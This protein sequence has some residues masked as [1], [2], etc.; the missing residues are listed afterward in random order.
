MTTRAATQSEFA[1]LAA[2]DLKNLMA[3][4]AQTT[5]E[6][7]AIAEK[8][9]ALE[10]KIAQTRADMNISMLLAIDSSTPPT[11]A[12]VLAAC[13]K[14]SQLL[15]NPVV[16]RFLTDCASRDLYSLLINLCYAGFSNNAGDHLSDAMPM[17]N[18]D[19]TAIAAQVQHDGRDFVIT[20]GMTK[21]FVLPRAIGDMIAG[22]H[23]NVFAAPFSTLAGRRDKKPTEPNVEYMERVNA[24]QNAMSEE[25]ETIEGLANTS[26][27]NFAPD[28]ALLTGGESLTRHGTGFA[29]PLLLDNVNMTH[30]N[31]INIRVLRH[32]AGVFEMTPI[33]FVKLARDDQWYTPVFTTKPHTIALS[34]RFVKT[35]V[36]HA[37]KSPFCIV[38]PYSG[39][40]F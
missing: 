9:R 39:L 7:A 26:H 2:Y 28:M 19:K 3:E 16:M 5:C 14:D 37:K 4:H 32:V 33:V 6:A 24:L 40:P 12:F 10:A 22:I 30:S 17:L 15:D 13:A 27:H 11:A 31:V 8:L 18:G 36:V 20:T 23:D 35:A 25:I 38:E 21:A 29:R 1:V 34:T